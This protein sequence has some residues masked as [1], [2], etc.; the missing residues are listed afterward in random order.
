MV[1]K[2]SNLI[3][4]LEA[5]IGKL[6]TGGGGGGSIADSSVIVAE[7]EEV[8]NGNFSAFHARANKI[9]DLVAQQVDLYHKALLTELELIKLASKSK[10]TRRFTS[11]SSTCYSSYCCCS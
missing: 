7:F 5:A 9:G 6:E 10:K 4:R 11:S 1:D 2:L 8:L 3:D